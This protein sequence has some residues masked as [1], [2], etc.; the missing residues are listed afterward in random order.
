VIR[1]LEMQ[2]SSTG[3]GPRFVSNL[4]GHDRN[5]RVSAFAFSRHRLLQRM[6]VSGAT[7]CSVRVWDAPSARCVAHHSDHSDGVTSVSLSPLVPDLVV[8]AD[9]TGVLVAWRR[10]TDSRKK[11]RPAMGGSKVKITCVACS[12]HAAAEVAVALQN[13]AVGI[14]DLLSGTVTVRLGGHEEEV[15]MLQWRPLPAQDQHQ[16]QHHNQ[17]QHHLLGS[18][19]RDRTIQLW[20]L[21]LP[22]PEE[23]GDL[24]GG[25]GGGGGGGCGGA[26]G[27]GRG[28]LL[29]KLALPRA[30]KQ[31]SSHQQGRLWLTFSWAD[32]PAGSGSGAGDRSG[33]GNGYEGCGP[34]E[35]G[36]GGD[37]GDND[38]YG[39]GDDGTVPLP[40]LRLLSSS[41]TGD[42]LA[43]DIPAGA[44]YAGNGNDFGG[45][46]AGGGGEAVAAPQALAGGHSRPVFSIVLAPQAAPDAGGAARAAAAMFAGGARAGAGAGVTASDA[47]ETMLQLSPAPPPL[48]PRAALASS[49]LSLAGGSGEQG[50]P[51]SG[52]PGTSVATTAA[53]AAAAAA[54]A[55][56]VASG[57]QWAFTISMDRELRV[58][59]RVTHRSTSTSTPSSSGAAA[60]GGRGHGPLSPP[61]GGPRCRFLVPGLG[62]HVYA[63]SASPPQPQLLALGVG[64]G[65]VRVWDI[66]GA[67]AARGQASG[68]SAVAI[69]HLPV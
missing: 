66:S 48:P 44:L 61:T 60:A 16:H 8:S 52:E 55:A 29:A 1:V 27:A 45:G 10:A 5:S 30:R 4:V 2:A 65:T 25:G 26:D 14:F 41:F 68:S 46:G 47:L 67:A 3:K 6:C 33:Y 34:N 51:P 57:S 43:W 56:A 62:G 36:G 58:W 18:S 31:L 39:F 28:W 12:P 54:A 24:G 64:D 7:D 50:G 22:T 69:Y 19:S 38:D 40:A 32:P 13:G 53:T 23:A 35:G 17:H 49:S 15:H 37:G 9:G 63:A 59:D 21:T 42:L 11:M 20:D